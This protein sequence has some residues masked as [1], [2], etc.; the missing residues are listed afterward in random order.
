MT[1]LICRFTA[2]TFS[3]QRP[4]RP[5]SVSHHNVGKQTSGLASNSCLIKIQISCKN[6]NIMQRLQYGECFTCFQALLCK[7]R[8]SCAEH[9]SSRFR[10]LCPHSNRF[11]LARNAFAEPLAPSL[12]QGT[13]FSSK[14]SMT[15]SPKTSSQPKR[16]LVSSRWSQLAE[17]RCV[18]A[19]L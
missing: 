12:A 1:E 10:C 14:N 18:G 17:T 16:L 19:G 13:L 5:F 2:V 3:P 4:W 6:T 15:H 11:F 9:T 7:S 8:R